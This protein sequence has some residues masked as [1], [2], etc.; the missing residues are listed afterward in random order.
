MTGQ[1][2]IEKDFYSALGVPKDADDAAIKKAYRKLARQY[3]PDQNPGDASAEAKF[4]EIGEAYAVLSDTEQRQQYDA[5]RAMA[6]GGARFAAGPGGGGNGFED[7]FGSMFGG[8]GAPNAR[9]TQYSQ[10][11]G[12]GFEDILSSMLGGQGGFRGGGGRQRAGFTAP[13]KGADVAAETTLPFRTAVEG[14]T[15]EFTVDG[16]KVKTKIPA[17]VNDGRKLRIRGKGRPGAGG[18]DA[19]DLVV[20]VHVSPHPVFTLDGANLRMSVPVTFAEAALG[21]TLE[22]P[23]LDGGTV[24]L[25]VPAGTPSGRVL[26]VKGRGVR[27]TKTQGDLLVTVQVA[28]PQ[29]LSR[30]AKEALEAFAAESDHEDVRAGLAQRAAE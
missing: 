2:W 25:K 19:G 9:Y 6:G 10:G 17:G 29:K 4:K 14:A 20:T 21:T 13:Q 18:G 27:T 28:V 24:R 5:V 16:R 26:R 8:Q 12:G 15:V 30:K 1:D 3:H 7:V 22:V 23:T 11:G